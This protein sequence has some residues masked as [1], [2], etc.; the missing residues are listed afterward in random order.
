MGRYGYRETTD[1]LLWLDTVVLR[2]E[3]Y[4]RHSIYGS[5]WWTAQPSGHQSSVSITSYPLEDQPHINLVY[6]T[7]LNETSHAL[8]YNILLTTTPCFFGGKRW[9]FL[10]PIVR[11]NNPCINRA[12]KLYKC[13]L[14]FGCRQCLQLAYPSQN[15]NHH[16]QWAVIGKIGDY[17]RELER[18]RPK[19]KIRYYKGKPTRKMRRH[20]KLREYIENRAALCYEFAVW[21]RKGLK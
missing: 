3:G 14:Y 4:L 12:R 15:E 10:C 6:T 17:E 16:S 13:G 18:L 5:L 11:D 8:N 20:I 9:W 1:G 19:I 21:L 7:R 2:K